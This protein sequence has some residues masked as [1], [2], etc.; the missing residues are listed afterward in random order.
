[1]PQWTKIPSLAS[2]YQEGIGRSWKEAVV[3]A[4]MA[5]MVENA[6]SFFNGM[7]FQG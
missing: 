1:M 6:E 3:G 2:S 4:L 7:E 5:S